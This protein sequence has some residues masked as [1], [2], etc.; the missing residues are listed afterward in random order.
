MERMHHSCGCTF[1]PV[2]SPSAL[3]RVQ[4]IRSEHSAQTEA[5]ET[6]EPQSLRGVRT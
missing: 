4:A 5:L 6:I 3:E 1:R 2:V